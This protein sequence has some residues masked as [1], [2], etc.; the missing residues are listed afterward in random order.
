[1]KTIKTSDLYEKAL[2][3][4]VAF[5]PGEPFYPNQNGG[6][7]SLRMC[8][9]FASPEDMDEGIKR[10]GEAMKELLKS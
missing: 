4:K 10:L 1:M 5:V 6:E 7:R 3:K 2:E 9:T 8:F